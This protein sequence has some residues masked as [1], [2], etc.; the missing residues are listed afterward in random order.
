MTCEFAVANLHKHA[1]QAAT[2]KVLLD[3]SDDAAL[4][5]EAADRAARAEPLPVPPPC[6]CLLDDRPERPLP[7]LPPLPTT[8]MLSGEADTG[9]LQPLVSVLSPTTYERCWTHESLYRCFA[10]Q[11]Y[12]PR[13]LI[14]LDTGPLPSPFFTT[15][16]DERVHYTHLPHDESAMRET[17]KKEHVT[18][19]GG[20]PAAPCH[21]SDA[22]E[23]SRCGESRRRFRR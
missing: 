10:H 5:P 20:R 23:R 16:D 6:R 9:S 18:T 22:Y 2:R 11:T 1:E 12:T 19:Q 8:A 7:A 13:E 15:L 14:V 17:E 3:V 21:R 4:L